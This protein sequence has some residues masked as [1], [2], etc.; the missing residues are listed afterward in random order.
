MA[1]PD[2]VSQVFTKY[3]DP[4]HGW[5]EVPRKLVSFL[6]LSPSAC[7]YQRGNMVYLEEDC[8]ASAFH[9]AFLAKYGS[10][11]KRESRHTNEVSEIREYE[12]YQKR[13]RREL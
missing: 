13:G 5:V 2:Y 10:A 8:D 4:G 12:C 7:S 3:C 1:K 11:Y 6:R 9:Y